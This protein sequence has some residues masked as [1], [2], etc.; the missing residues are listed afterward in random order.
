VSISVWL[1]APVVLGLLTLHWLTG[2]WLVKRIR[3]LRDALDMREILIDD[4]RDWAWIS[5]GGTM[6]LT[7]DQTVERIRITSKNEARIRVEFE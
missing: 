5:P 3:A 1:Y 7:L 6:V 4:R 2:Y